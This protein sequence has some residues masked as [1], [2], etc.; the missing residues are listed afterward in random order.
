MLYHSPEQSSKI[1]ISDFGLSRIEDGE[2]A[3]AIACGTPGYV[4][5]A[6]IHHSMMRMT[7]NYFAKYEECNMNS[8]L[9]IGTTFRIQDFIR[10]LLKKD[11]QARYSCT[12]ALKHPWIASNVA[13][14]LNIYPQVSQ[15]IRKNF[16]AWQRW[17]VQ[18]QNIL[19]FY[20]WSILCFLN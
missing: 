3:T 7:K 15:N 8:I 17:K 9:H 18:K 4:G 6:V 11:P 13:K 5:C 1:M 2:F 16:L 12:Q 14:D 20:T 19:I 10:N